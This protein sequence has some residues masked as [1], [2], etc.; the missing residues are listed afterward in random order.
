MPRSGFGVSAGGVRGV[1]GEDGVGGV[2]VAGGEGGLA[3][4]GGAGDEVEELAGDAVF[5]G[6][7][8]EVVGVG[9]LGGGGFGEL[10]GR[11]ESSACGDG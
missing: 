2:F 10:R 1:G 5:G 9:E 8:V 11:S 7:G 6:D 3:L 4:G